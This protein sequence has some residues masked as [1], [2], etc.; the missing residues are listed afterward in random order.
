MAHCWNGCQARLSNCVP[1]GMDFTGCNDWEMLRDQRITSHEL[2]AQCSTGN[3]GA[4]AESRCSERSV[5]IIFEAQSVP[6]R[7]VCSDSRILFAPPFTLDLESLYFSSVHFARESQSSVL[8]SLPWSLKTLS[9]SR[10][11][12]PPI[13]LHSIL[14]SSQPTLTSLNLLGLIPTETV[15][16]PE[17]SSFVNILQNLPSIKTLHLR[18]EEFYTK[19]E[20]QFIHQLSPKVPFTRID[21]SYHIGHV[22]EFLKTLS[23]VLKESGLPKTVMLD[24]GKV[25]F[26][27]TP[28]S[29]GALRDFLDYFLKF[30]KY[31]VKINQAGW[32]VLC[33]FGG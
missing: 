2:W 3:D 18:S 25:T 14:T 32:D 20:G 33:S 9:L 13:L 12:F 21:L 17:M 8:P 29:V 15:A 7:E 19:S 1:L 28:Q 23:A 26:F 4:G 30:G 22:L 6:Q 11:Y 10:V 16:R 31:A 24:W 27:E 5:H